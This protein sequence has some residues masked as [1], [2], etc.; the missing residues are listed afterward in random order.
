MSQL[1]PQP[2]HAPPIPGAAVPPPPAPQPPVSAR[3]NA[4]GVLLAFGCGL[5]LI[6]TAALVLAFGAGPN[7]PSPEPKTPEPGAGFGP[8]RS[9]APV[10]NPE[11]EKIAQAVGRGLAYLKSQILDRQEAYYLND[12]GGGSTVGVRALAGLTLLECGLSAADPA[13]QA[14]AAEVRSRTPTIT[15]TYSL[16]L[17]ILF[18]DKLNDVPAA[19]RN[20]SD[21]EL[22]RDLALRLVA[23]QN[24]HGGW[25][26]NTPIRSAGELRTLADSLRSRTFTPG[27]HPDPYDDNSINQ[28]VTLALWQARKHDVRAEPSLLLVERRYRDNQNP[29]GSWGYRSDPRFNNLKDATTCAGLIG[30]AVGRACEDVEKARARPE[31]IQEDPAVKKGFA[32][33]SASLGRQAPPLT[34]EEVAKRRRHTAEMMALYRDWHSGPADR[35]EGIEERLRELDNAAWLRGTYIDADAWGDLY[36]LWSVER[37]GVIYDR[38]VIGGVD[39]YRLG[40]PILLANQR[41]DGSWRDRFPGIPDTCFALLFLKRINVVKELTDKLRTLAQAP[42]ISAAPR[43][44]PPQVIVEPIRLNSPP[45]TL[46]RVP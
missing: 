11:K 1:Q 32:F 36:F 31:P 30:L 16:C 23:A 12:P 20:P 7:A 15:F 17:A 39:W 42:A 2:R 40:V 27:R 8:V 5:V 37:V 35:R 13:V 22:L 10:V 18:L 24:A 44:L 33:L 26:Y 21:L 3:G 46:P 41:A 4:L 6:A 38:Q 19:Q 25:G 29:D 28:F 45:K 34:K 43:P 9:A 14:V